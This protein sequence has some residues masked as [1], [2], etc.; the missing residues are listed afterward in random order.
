VN[1]QPV[2]RTRY[3]YADTDGRR[4][5]GTSYATGL[6]LDAGTRV[7][8]EYTGR[9]AAV[10]RITG[11][12]TTPVG[13]GIAFV[14]LFPLAGGLVALVGTYK[15]IRAPAE[16]GTY[17]VVGHTH[18]PENLEDEPQERVVYDPRNP[19]DAAL[20]DELPCRPHVDDRGDFTTQGAHEPLIALL[21][22]LSPGLA[23]IVL[24][25][26]VLR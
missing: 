26:F 25:G 23:L 3:H 10:S 6:H 7:T 14:L 22:L 2:Y 13:L 12:R 20:L 21:N 4:L 18:R 5:V 11:M 8:V 15:G 17:E 1:D 24:F 9:N 16:G 19:V